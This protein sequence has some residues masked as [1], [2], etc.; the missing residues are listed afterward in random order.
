VGRLR[1]GLGLGS[2]PHVVGQLGS[3]PRVVRRLGSRV[4]VSA[5]F[6]IF[7]LTAGGGPG[8]NVLGGKGNCPTGEMSGGICLRGECPGEKCPTLT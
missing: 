8:G 7:A 4:W 6:Q 5:S 3:V 2:G 1:L